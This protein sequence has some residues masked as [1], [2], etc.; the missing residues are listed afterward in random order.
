MGGVARASVVRTSALTRAIWGATLLGAPRP[1]LHVL[2]GRQTPL[3]R[4]ILRVLGARHLVQATVT[5]LHPSRAVLAGG[6][7]LD[8][9]H[10]LTDLAL[11][12][13]DPSQ[14]RLALT[15]AGIAA[16]WIGLDLRAARR[17]HAPMRSRSQLTRAGKHAV[18]PMSRRIS[19]VL[20]R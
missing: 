20:P 5:A 2:G 15:D 3:A 7:G 6:A 8:G 18:R 16:T 11:A 17:A 10:A 9:L 12:V 19:A 1:V 14:K 4:M 13:L